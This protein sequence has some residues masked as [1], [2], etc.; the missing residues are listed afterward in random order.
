MLIRNMN[1][2]KL[3]AASGFTLI[4]LLVAFAILALLSTI[5]FGQ[6]RT[7]QMKARD[8]R[9]NSDISNVARA[10]EM[11]YN[12][13]QAYP[14]PISLNWGSEF[15]TE[16]VVYMKILPQDPHA[17]EGVDY[18]YESDGGYYL[19][20]TMLENNQDPNFFDQDGDGVGDYSCGG[21]TGYSYGVSSTNVT[22][23]PE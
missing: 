6:Y 20:Y 21:T 7:S 2:N 16:T 1:F 11:Y 18:C 12:D 13:H 23:M 4:E 19:L 9:R 10:L 8:S 14:Q 5:A 15:A 17:S 22:M 3:K